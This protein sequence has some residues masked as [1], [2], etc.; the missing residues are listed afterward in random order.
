MD[1]LDGDVVG[2]RPRL[3][4]AADGEKPAAG[5][6]LLGQ[7]PTDAG[8]PC[9]VPREQALIR[10]CAVC[11]QSLEAV[12]LGDHTVACVLA[13]RAW[14][15]WRHSSTPSYVVALTRSLRTPGLTASRW[16]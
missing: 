5:E 12:D 2:V 13:T 15:H 6:E 14:S 16:Y 10:L 3:R 7:Q 11:E 4:G 1:E 9:R 8:D